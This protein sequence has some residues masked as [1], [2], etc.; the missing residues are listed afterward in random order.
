GQANRLAFLNHSK[1]DSDR[2]SAERG[3]AA[4]VPSQVNAGEMEVI[5]RSSGDDRAESDRIPTIVGRNR[6]QTPRWRGSGYFWNSEK[7]VFI[8]P[9]LEPYGSFMATSLMAVLGLR[10]SGRGV[11][12]ATDVFAVHATGAEMNRLNFVTSHSRPAAGVLLGL[13]LFMMT[14]G[15]SA[16]TFS[17]DMQTGLDNAEF[18]FDQQMEG[19][20]GPPVLDTAPPPPA[21]DGDAVRTGQI[22][23]TDDFGAES[24]FFFDLQGPGTIRFRWRVD[25]PAIDPDNPNV[26]GAT[27]TWQMFDPDPFSGAPVESDFITGFV[28]WMEIEI[29]VP[30]GNRRILISYIAEVDAPV[31]GTFENAGWVDHLRWEPEDDGPPPEPVIEDETATGSGIARAFV[32]SPDGGEECSVTDAEFL[33]PPEAP[34]TGLDLPH[35]LLGFTSSGCNPGFSVNVSV[36]YPQDIG[37]FAAYWKYDPVEGWFAIP[38]VVD[39][40]TISFTLTDGGPGDFS[41]VP[42]TITDPGGIG[43]LAPTADRIFADRFEQRT[44]ADCPDC[45]TMVLVPAGSFVQGAPESEPLSGDRERPQR[46]VNVPAFALGQTAVTFDQ[47]D[48]CVANDGCTYT[49]G[50]SGWGRGNR[51]VIN[52]SWNDAQQYVIWL[53][54]KTGQDYRLPSESEWEYAA[55]AGTTTRFNTGDCITTDQAN[56]RGTEPAEG[57]PPGVSLNRTLPVASFAPNTLG[58]YDTHGNVRE[59]VKDCSN[60]SYVGAPTDGSAWMSGDCSAALRRGGSWFT[61]GN[62]VRSATRITTERDSRFTDGGFRVARSLTP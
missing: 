17:Q 10:C 7:R 34:P 60:T 40:N 22:F 45:P 49:P 43:I 47:W 21:V 27:L 18:E 35:G 48:A 36:E 2:A 54:K 16:Q 44:F 24:G 15:L 13:G 26:R 28:D 31:S 41:G 11:P 59:W 29:D 12:A 20:A 6:G 8:L 37:E 4:L 46:Q 50:D 14:G 32:D 30:E 25:G 57:C 55:R 19:D 38:S 33:L 42:G 62:S 23:G 1:L 5:R 51:P 39:G 3:S 53:S 58:L 52:V 61:N 9:I 56:F